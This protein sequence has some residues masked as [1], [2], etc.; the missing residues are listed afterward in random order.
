[1]DFYKDHDGVLVEEMFT[2]LIYSHRLP[3]GQY[4]DAKSIFYEL[5]EISDNQSKKNPKKKS[6]LS[7]ASCN[8][9]LSV[10]SKH[11]VL[12]NDEGSEIIKMMKMNK[13]SG[14]EK[15]ELKVLE[16][17]TLSDN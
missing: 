16:K 15:P 3:Y 4:E 5:K 7:V 13:M 9:L 8:A 2:S 17:C 1:M 10:Y 14:N 12:L 11:E 6:M